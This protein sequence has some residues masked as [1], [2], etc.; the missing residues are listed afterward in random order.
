MDGIAQRASPP[1]RVNRRFAG[2]VHHIERAA[3]HTGH[4]DG[5]IG[6]FAFDLR[7]ARRSV[8]HGVGLAFRQQRR[9]QCRFHIAIFGVHHDDHAVVGGDAHGVEERGVIDLEDILVRHEE[10]QAG[11]AFVEHGRDFLHDSVV[12]VGH[13]HV[14]AIIDLRQMPRFRPPGLQPVMQAAA[15]GLHHEI[16]MRRRAAECRGFYARHQSRRC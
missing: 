1:Q 14:K 16:D 2:H 12:E 11:D 7:R 15:D 3:G 4:D 9:R 8:K 6:R 13:R 5:A 10:L